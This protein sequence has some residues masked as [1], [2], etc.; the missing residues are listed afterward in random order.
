MS[1]VSV[2]SFLF[3]T[4]GA[5]KVKSELNN[6]DR[7]E[8]DTAQSA[9]KLADSQK[10]LSSSFSNAVSS[11]GQ[12]VATYVGFKAVLGGIM[13]FSQQGEELALMAY[14]AGV[15][16]ETLERYGTALKNYGGG[17]SSAAS[18]LSTLSSQLQDLRFGGGGA[19]REVALRYG[20]SV[21]GKNGIA[22]AEEFLRNIA[23]RMES[24]GTQQQID[25]GKRL[26]LDPATLALVRGG[27]ANLNAELEKANK[28]SIYNSK[29]IEQSRK[30]QASLRELRAH[31]ER[32]SAIVLRS[33][34]PVVTQVTDIISR[35]F[36]YIADHK[37]FVL[38][39]FGALA[40]VLGVI[41]IASLA[42][43]W[44]IITMVGAFIAAGT[45]IGLL[46]DDFMTF[47]EGG[48]SVT[49]KV[50]DAFADLFLFLLEV[51]ED[52]KD[53]FG[54]LW[55]SIVD[56][57]AGAFGT[58]LEYWDNIKSIFS[59][60]IDVKGMMGKGVDVIS[61]TASGLWTSVTNMFGGA[62][63]N[64]VNID[65][66]NVNTQATDAAGIASGLSTELSTEFEDLLFQNTGGQRI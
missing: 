27:V 6:L 35:F 24:L 37:G 26:G 16:A 9:Y 62:S 53:F 65:T 25:L 50:A 23:R 10:N 8:K 11:V 3:E 51:G 22:T 2:F 59:G 1:I 48:E 5:D 41:A 33:L 18:T 64:K 57:F 56:G 7:A 29:D 17:L 32:I 4:E 60:D 13:G 61:D 30:F 28:L 12:L 42:A 40:S 54:G 38:G 45:A 34:L 15:G 39:F 21:S 20:I 31:L 52:I 55:D 46:V 14:N 47:A 66:I 63:E 58:I 19:I 43:S 44:P 49:G 36:S